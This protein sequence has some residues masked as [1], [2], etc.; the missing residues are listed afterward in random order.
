MGGLA[1]SS[2]GGILAPRESRDDCLRLRRCQFRPSEAGVKPEEDAGSLAAA[3]PDLRP[4]DIR[5]GHAYARY[6][7]EPRGMHAWRV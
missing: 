6:Q 2:P 4:C 7:P 5:R 1:G 3:K